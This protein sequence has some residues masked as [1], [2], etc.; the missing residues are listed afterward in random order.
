VTAYTKQVAEDKL[1]RIFVKLIG[2]QIIKL[3]QWLLLT[4]KLWIWKT[5]F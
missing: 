4:C 2:L 5:L 3:E 1:N